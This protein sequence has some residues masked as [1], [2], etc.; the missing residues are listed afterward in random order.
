MP[1]IKER[2]DMNKPELFFKYLLDYGTNNF[3]HFTRFNKS[4]KEEKELEYRNVSRGIDVKIIMEKNGIRFVLVARM[5]KNISINN[6]NRTFEKYNNDFSNKSGIKM[7][8]MRE[9]NQLDKSK[10]SLFFPFPTER[11]DR[12]FKNYIKELCS[13][14]EE[15][16]CLVKSL[17]E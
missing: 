15:I 5:P 11:T 6:L 8:W 17:E 13:K 16:V 4:A 3:D 10:S 14:M 9:S 2:N 7:N 12:E 1:L